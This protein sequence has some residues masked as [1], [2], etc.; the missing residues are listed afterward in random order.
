MFI[1]FLFTELPS[2]NTDQRCDNLHDCL[3]LHSKIITNHAWLNWVTL[4]EVDNYST[5]MIIYYS[6]TMKIIYYYTAMVLIYYST[7]MVII[8]YSTTLIG[9]F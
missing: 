7:A 2:K 1:C 3:S 9:M 4:C 8:Y 6:T 5:A